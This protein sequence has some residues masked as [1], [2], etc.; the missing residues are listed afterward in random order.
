MRDHIVV[1]VLALCS[2]AAFSDEAR[3]W[4]R[5][6]S[7]KRSER[8]NATAEK[9]RRT[10]SEEIRT[11]G[12]HEWAGNYYYGDGQGVNA[13]LIVAPQS[14]YLFQWR[15]CLGLY[16]R[17]YGAITSDKG[18][19]RLSFTFP[20][21]RS[22]FQ[23]IAEELIP[24]AW[25]NR[26]YLVPSDDIVG[27]CNHVNEGLEPRN[28]LSGS[29]LLQ[30]GDQKKKV[31]GFPNVPE[32]FKPYLLAHPVEAEITGVGESTTRPI[33]SDWKYKDTP[34]TLSCGRNKGLLPGMR[35][36]VIAP[37]I[38]LGFVEVQKSNEGRS[39]AVTTQMGRSIEGPQI[40]WK[41][42]TRRR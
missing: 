12:S 21:K 8:A 5:V 23:G 31:T 11:I 19:L 17:N 39:E 41:L 29:Y 42:S 15:G 6:L 2:T 4:D 34:V 40:G 30:V 26:M 16:D 33:A 22:G 27:F 14:G 10:I 7:D 37:K 28:R 9:L 32:Q 35:L 18:R 24:I 38:V 20:N 3:D 25:G 1:G 36:Y 13:H